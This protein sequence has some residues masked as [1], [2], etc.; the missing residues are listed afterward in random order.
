[1]NIE[2]N[3]TY[4]FNL[5]VCS[6]RLTTIKTFKEEYPENTLPRECIYALVLGHGK[7]HCILRYTGIHEW[8]DVLLVAPTFQDN[9]AIDKQFNIY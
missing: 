5:G 3:K 1:M 4:S 2:P 8:W 9:S 7:R 6:A